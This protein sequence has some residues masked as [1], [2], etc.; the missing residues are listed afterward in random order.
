MEIDF[1]GIGKEYAADRA[2][3]VIVELGGMH[4]LVNLGGDVRVMGPHA[5]GQAWRIAVQDPR[6]EPGTTIAH[7][8]VRVAI[9]LERAEEV[10]QRSGRNVRRR[11]TVGGDE[12][13]GAKAL[14][15]DR[16]GTGIGLLPGFVVLIQLGA[17]VRGE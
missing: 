5:D 17:F 12:R 13:V 3:A 14:K 8:N 2:A 15:L 1:G 16:A 7:L 10:A 9:E 4:G 11:R 6:G